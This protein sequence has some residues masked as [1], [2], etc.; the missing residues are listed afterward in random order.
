MPVPREQT[1]PHGSEL[2][3]YTDLVERLQKLSASPRVKIER[4]E[5]TVE[6]RG[7]FNIVIADEAVIP[8]LDYHRTLAAQAQ[9][10]TVK[11]TTLSEKT[12]SPKPFMPPDVHYSVTIMGQTFGHEASHVEGLVELAEHLAWGDDDETKAILARLIVQIIPMI[13]PDGREVGIELWKRVPLAE[14]GAAVGNRYGFYINR[15]FLHLTQPEGRAALEAF[16]RW[17]PLALYDT[18]EDAYLLY[19]SV[20]EVCWFPPDGMSSAARAPQNIRDIVTQLGGGIRKQWDA[21][22]YKYYPGDMF[23]FPMIGQSPDEPERIPTGNITTTMS[24]HGVPS[25][26]TESSR[27]PGAQTWRDRIDQKHT[28]GIGVLLEVASDPEAIAS[29]IYGNASALLETQ[30]GY[31]IPKAQRELDAVAY[32]IDTLLRHEVA[33][34][35]VE[36]PEPAYVIPLAQA[37]AP[38]INDLLSSANSKL[39]AMPPALNVRVFPADERYANVPLTPVFE[40]PQPALEIVGEVGSSANI[41]IPNTADGVTLLNR[42]WHVGAPVYWLTE[43]A[44][45][46]EAGSFVVE[47]VP[48]KTLRFAATGLHLRVTAVPANTTVQARRLSKPAIALYAGQGVDRPTPAPTAD[49]WWGLE[50]LEFDFTLFEAEQVTEAELSQQSLFIV[51]EGNA[52]DIVDGWNLSS[53]RSAAAWDLPGTPRGIGQSG[54]AAIRSFVEAGGDYLG[55]GTGGG[56][57]AASEYAGMIDLT[58]LYHSLGTGRINLKIADAESPLFAGLDGVYGTDGEWQPGIFPALYDTE[59]MSNKVSGPV[60][61]AGAGV[62]A[63]AYYDGADVNPDERYLLHAE[64]FDAREKGIAVALQQVG[65]GNVIVS[66]IRPGFRAFWRYAFKLVSN[67]A[68]ASAAAAPQSVTLV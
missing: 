52:N 32:L 5:T 62:T 6:G 40:A 2:I 7:I 46:V 61:H 44:G 45:D 21:R 36:T 28:A 4:L 31:V 18:H 55:F 59:T 9:R 53:R 24:L 23:A 42:L 17:H 68:L 10:P 1:Q 16:T 54:L 34:Y 19:V 29:T 8:N 41:A 65:E 3:A 39:V 49:L 56:L 50:N 13:N 27:T 11:H 58:V 57:L 20:P 33:V 22:G 37:A 67:T 26:I 30:G 63:L 12:V 48:V 64:L 51:P 15:D 35:D 47:N 25:L 43:A 38:L 66:G 60:F 14:D